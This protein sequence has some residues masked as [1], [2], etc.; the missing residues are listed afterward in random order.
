[1]SP[2]Y[3]NG[4]FL[5]VRKR[6]LSKLNLGENI[7]FNHPDLGLMVKRLVQI[8]AEGTAEA[9]GLHPN[10]IGRKDLGKIQAQ[11]ILGKVIWHIKGPAHKAA[12]AD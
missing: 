11:W 10:S 6:P 1:M 3:L 5:L 9:E 2:L 4:D 7:I 8:D 12:E